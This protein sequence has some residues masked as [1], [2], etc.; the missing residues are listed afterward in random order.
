MCN[1]H[2]K[3]SFEEGRAWSFR[4]ASMV[5]RV[6]FSPAEDVVE[7]DAAS[8]AG[9]VTFPLG[10]GLP[11]SMWNDFPGEYRGATMLLLQMELTSTA[12][13]AGIDMFKELHI[14]V[15]LIIRGCC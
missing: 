14:S 4:N 5:G 12:T 3:G 15:S 13:L 11:W 9:S 2:R 7:T 6:S 8:V 1:F 10:G